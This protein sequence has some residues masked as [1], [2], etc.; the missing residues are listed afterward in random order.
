MDDKANDKSAWEVTDK[1]YADNAPGGVASSSPALPHFV[2]DTGR[3]GQGP[4]DVARYAEAPYHQPAEVI[5]GL[6]AGAWCNPPGMGLG[7][8]PTADTGVPLL[9]AYLWIKTA[10][11]SDG[12]CDIAGNARAWDFAKY[13][14]W[15][16]SGEGQMRFDP[17]WGMVLPAAGMWF[18]EQALELAQKAVPPLVP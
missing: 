6:V 14:P 1:W 10:G 2:I 13:N 9:D 5:R 18:P 7:L 11:E 12:S 15:G 4:L 17:L 8:R 16:I 3:N